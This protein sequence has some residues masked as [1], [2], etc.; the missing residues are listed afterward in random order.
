MSSHAPDTCRCSVFRRRDPL[1]A[2][3]LARWRL[4]SW[5]GAPC[6]L[7]M[8]RRSHGIGAALATRFHG[9]FRFVQVRTG[10]LNKFGK[11]S[12]AVT[13]HLLS[14][15]DSSST[16]PTRFADRSFHLR[17]GRPVPDTLMSAHRMMSP[18]GIQI[19]VVRCNLSRNPALDGRFNLSAIGSEK[20]SAACGYT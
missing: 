9:Q 16:Y 14:R 20:R 3:G 11:D 19:E 4:W 7:V 1:F 12:P 15:T 13:P 17:R 10:F 6:S 2:L 8:K 5:R 18:V